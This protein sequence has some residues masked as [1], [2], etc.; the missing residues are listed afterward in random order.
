MQ[1]QF[2]LI[3]FGKS[4]VLVL[5]YFCSDRLHDYSGLA[6]HS[7]YH[8]DL[9]NILKA[10]KMVKRPFKSGRHGPDKDNFDIRFEN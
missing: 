9:S 2:N 10:R 8:T 7:H 6:F 5:Y 3:E 4:R 1:G